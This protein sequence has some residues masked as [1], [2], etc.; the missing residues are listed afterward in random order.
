MSKKT[1]DRRPAKQHGG[2]AKME[3]I[4]LLLKYKEQLKIKHY[5]DKS[6]SSYE[7]CLNKFL[8]YLSQREKTIKE[9]TKTDITEY[10]V[11]LKQKNYSASTRERNLQS[12]KGFFK[13]LEENFYILDNPT[14][15][16]VLPK[17]EKRIPVVLTESE[18]KKILQQPNTSTLSGIRDRTI[19]EVLY[20]TGI[21][22]NELHN[23]TIYDLD[24]SSGF[25][26]I[27]Q[28]KFSKDRF[29]PL[30]KISCYYLKEYIKQ[31]RPVFSRNRL[32]EK[33]L[34]IGRSGKAINKQII[35]ELIRNYAKAAKINKKVTAHTFRHTCATH[36]LE[37][38]VDIFKIQKLLGHSRASI[39]QQYTKVS[40]R[41]I[42]QVHERCHPLEQ[43]SESRIQKSENR[44]QRTEDG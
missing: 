4:E 41:Q 29:V 22:L 27:T 13:Y 43:M 10:R 12:I 2:Q 1:K 21:R 8:Q 17:T 14:A 24:I 42:K 30:T 25:L 26:R 9:L 3:D 34:F 15:G 37:H 18:V 16:L 6:I 5:A 44:R 31:V 23:L 36:L 11:Y 32:Q 20:S 40:P 38:N 28:G 33:A 35:S 7:Y 39:T 19:L